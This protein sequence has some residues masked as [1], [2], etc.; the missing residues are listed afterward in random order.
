MLKPKDVDDD[1][2]YYTMNTLGL[3]IGNYM[4]IVK[5]KQLADSAL[6]LSSSDDPNDHTHA[7]GLYTLAIEEFGKAVILKEHFI[8]DDAV[9]QKIPKNIFKGKSAHDIKFKKA[10]ECLPPECKNF[11][12][13][14]YR[15]F[16]SGIPTKDRLGMKGPLVPVPAGVDGIF[17]G[18]Y[19][20]NM[21]MRMSSFF[22]DWDD[23]RRKWV[24]NM[25]VKKKRTYI[26]R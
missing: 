20:A 14:T 5:A 19:T 6:R 18:E 22:V 12:V 21:D 24:F 4:C 10:I 7:L 2:S 11:M 1:D 23:T 15:A 8:D 25:K 16:R 13:G 3:F 26:G 17:Y 9:L